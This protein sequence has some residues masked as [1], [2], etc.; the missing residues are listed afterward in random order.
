MWCRSSPTLKQ[1]DNNNNV[2]VLLLF[3]TGEE[4]VGTWSRI[5]FDVERTV[6]VK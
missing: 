3:L 1:N 5:G 4:L 6:G 2:N